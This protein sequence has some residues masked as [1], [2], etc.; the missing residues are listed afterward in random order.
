M[1]YKIQCQLITFHLFQ[2]STRILSSFSYYNRQ[3]KKK[4]ERKEGQEMREEK[5]VLNLK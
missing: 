2:D 4:R 5:D 3:M 1:I